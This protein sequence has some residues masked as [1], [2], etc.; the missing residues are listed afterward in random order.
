MTFR[1]VLILVE[2]TNHYYE[3]VF[4]SQI[5]KVGTNPKLVPL[6]S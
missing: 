2:K 5:L 3:I 6:C 4:G 1:N